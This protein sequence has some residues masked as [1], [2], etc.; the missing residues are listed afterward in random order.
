MLCLME[1]LIQ[2]KGGKHLHVYHVCADKALIGKAC[3]TNTGLS[4]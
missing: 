1:L 4:R 3:N 2:D